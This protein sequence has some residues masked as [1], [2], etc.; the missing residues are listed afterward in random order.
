MRITGKY[1]YD[2]VKNLQEAG[3]DVSLHGYND[4]YRVCNSQGNVNI[5]PF[6]KPGPMHLWLLGFVAGMD[7]YS[8]EILRK[9]VNG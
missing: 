1:L 2:F 3:Y 9:V 8:R 5:S 7:L 6:L 4:G